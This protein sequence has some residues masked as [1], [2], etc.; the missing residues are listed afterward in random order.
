MF[1]YPS[2]RRCV[3]VSATYLLLQVGVAR[4]ADISIVYDLD[5]GVPDVSS[6]VE[7]PRLGPCFEYPI[8][9]QIRVV[10]E[11]LVPRLE[12]LSSSILVPPDGPN[13]FSIPY[14]ENLD[15]F[16]GEYTS[17][18]QSADVS[19]RFYLTDAPVLPP[20]ELYV[21]LTEGRSKL[22][23]TGGYVGIALDPDPNSVLFQVHGLA[24]PE[25]TTLGLMVMAAVGVTANRRRR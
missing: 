11:P 14:W 21:E 7:C 5:A 23:L 6:V 2:V 24:V 4:S 13:A 20:Y 12:N 16:I 10:L 22:E 15:Q 17:D 3:V 1:T 18:A 8:N 25:P 9:G 19:M